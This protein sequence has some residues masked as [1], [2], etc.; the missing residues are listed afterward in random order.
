[1][2]QG[3][4]FFV[5][6]H[7]RWGKSSTLAA[8]TGGNPHVK[9]H[10]VGGRDFFIRRMSN[11]D[12]PADWDTFLDALDPAQKPHV[13]LTVCPKVAAMPVLQ[14]LRSRYDLHFW[15]MQQSWDGKR[16][17]TAGE[18][19]SLRSLGVADVFVQRVP[20]AQ[21]APAFKQFIL[22]HP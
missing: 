1:M 9:W 15:V 11:D 3:K 4:A 22:A 2:V 19:H 5:V 8:L 17:I 10:S 21:R 18:E 7:E 14:R 20:P 6:G 13:I 16:V 12:I